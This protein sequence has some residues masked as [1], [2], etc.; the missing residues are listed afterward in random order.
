MNL[1]SNRG[2]EKRLSLCICVTD[3]TPTWHVL[4]CYTL[5]STNIYFGV[6]AYVEAYRSVYGS[7]Q[8]N[9]GVRGGINSSV[10]SR[11]N[12]PVYQIS[13]VPKLHQPRKFLRLQTRMSYTLRTFLVGEWH[14]S[15]M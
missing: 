2:I 1:L 13:R 9:C 15:R 12:L 8:K 4:T 7:V 3:H 11:E 14:K 6:Y 5:N 10:I